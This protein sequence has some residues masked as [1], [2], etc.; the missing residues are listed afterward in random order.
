MSLADLV[1]GTGPSG[2]GFSSTAEEVTH[3]LNLDGRTVL[4]I[5]NAADGRI[6]NCDPQMINVPR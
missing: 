1:K 6:V 4:V 2:F 5:D 3:G